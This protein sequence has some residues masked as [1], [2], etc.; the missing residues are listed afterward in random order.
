MGGNGYM[1]IYC[2]PVSGLFGNQYAI[3]EMAEDLS[4]LGYAKDA[5]LSTMHVLLEIRKAEIKIEA[6]KED[7]RNVW[8]AMERWD[9]GPERYN[10][11][12]FKEA[13]AQYRGED[14]GD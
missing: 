14:K 1:N 9:S 5:A 10:E 6:M 11:E 8:H 3:E 2:D 7:L 12:S 13:L 4:K